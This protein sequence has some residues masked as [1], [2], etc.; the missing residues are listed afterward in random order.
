[1]STLN[2]F[3]GNAFSVVSLTDAVNKIPHTPG[4]AGQVVDW[5][6]QGVNTTSIM[7]EETKGQLN[8]V[9]PTPRGGPGATLGKDKRT[10]RILAVPHYQI[11]DAIYAEEVQNVRAFGSETMVE[12][13]QTK[14]N[15]RLSD[16]VTQNLDPTLEHQR[17][18]AIKG[19]ILTGSGDTLYN[20]FT[21]FDVT[22]QDTVYLSLAA[23]ASTSNGGIRSKCTQMVRSIARSLGGVAYS[24]VHAFCG[25]DFWDKLIAAK[26]TRETFQA[27]EAAQLR[28]GVAF[29]TF[30][31][32][33]ILFENYR[34]A[35]GNVDADDDMTALIDA[36]EA[37]VFPVGVPGLFRTVFAPADYIETVNTNGLPRYARQYPMPNGKGVSLESQMNALSYC[38]RPRALITADLA[39]SGT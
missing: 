28:N 15:S 39:A 10:A 24:G 30:L 8:L 18:G 5:N 22:Q 20:L 3:K 1:M 29:S 37:H 26:E 31:Y 9:D 4:R 38:T 17:L 13:V 27:Q 33:G 19:V 36:E 7:L 32:G 21:E 6:E 2:V 25:D 34:G 23:A 35:I 12:S 16:H 11:D 14:V